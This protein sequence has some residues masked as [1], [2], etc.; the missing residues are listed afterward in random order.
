[1]K[2]KEFDT[3]RTKLLRGAHEFYERLEGLLEGQKDRESR[4]A[5]GRA[6]HDVGEL[7]ALIG[8]REEALVVHQRALG[9]FEEVSREAPDEPE[10]RYEIGRSCIA[11]GSLQ[12]STARATEAL[13]ALERA[14]SILGALL[15]AGVG[16]DKAKSELAEAEHY[17]GATGVRN[18]SRSMSNLGP[19]ERAIGH[20]ESLG[21]GQSSG[22]ATPNGARIGLR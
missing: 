3:L 12:L 7:T 9:L 21:R 1:M 5:L 6:Y 11:I 16:D 22:R 13:A 18:G 10:P 19:Y 15:E 4:L 8:S 14:R 17:Y 2:Q 20:T